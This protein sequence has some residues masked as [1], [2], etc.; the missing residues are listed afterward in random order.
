MAD[1]DGD[2][3]SELLA[4]SND[5]NADS[6]CGAIPGYVARRGVFAYRDA[7]DRWAYTRRSWT[8]H[9]HHVTNAT[10]T[11]LTTSPEAGNWADPR[12][13]DFRQNVDLPH[14]LADLDVELGVDFG[15][16][17]GDLQ[18]VATVRNRGDFAAPSGVTVTLYRGTDDSGELVSTES[19][20]AA[21]PPGGEVT[22]SWSEA[23]DMSSD[24][25]VVVDSDD[26][27]LECDETNG[28]ASAVDVA[29]R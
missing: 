8:Q 2:G 3:E 29:C 28:T 6:D 25:F 14:G 7:E 18:V 19:T 1:V 10:S 21:L 13:N 17:P 5:A 16:C 9:T 12:L 15:G 11:G 26:A 20:A 23:S 27:V 24:Y 22:L 4:G